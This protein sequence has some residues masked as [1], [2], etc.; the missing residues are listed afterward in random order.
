MEEHWDLYHMA[1]GRF[2]KTIVKSRDC[3]PEGL[4]HET[5]E[6]IPTDRKGHLLLTM[7]SLS[8]VNSGGK[9]EFPAGSVISGES[10]LQAARRELFEETGLKAAKMQKLGASLIPGMKRYIYIAHIPDLLNAQVHLQEGETTA[11]RFATYEE[12]MELADQNQFDTS[13]LAL[14][15]N[16]IH[17]SIQ[18][19]VGHPDDPPQRKTLRVLQTTQDFPGIPADLIP[20]EHT[21]TDNTLSDLDIQMILDAANGAET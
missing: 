3:V 18:H 10:P 21:S 1:D 11:Y 12:W 16:A 13:R 20:P 4:Y 8:K 17:N 9:Y 15:S 7:R 2:V 6:V 5:V 19:L 14:Y